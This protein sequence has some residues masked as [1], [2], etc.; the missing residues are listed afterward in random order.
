MRKLINVLV[1]G[2]IVGVSS[3]SFAVTVQG[4]SGTT[5]G[6]L[7]P[8]DEV[9]LRQQLGQLA[10]AFGIETK[11]PDAP[12]QSAQPAANPPAEEKKTMAEV[13]DKA[14]DMASGLVASVAATLQKVAPQVWRIMIKQQYA[15]AAGYLIVP[16]GLVLLGVIYMS[17]I[18]SK[19]SA[20]KPDADR[21]SREDSEERAA[22]QIITT[23]LPL[24][25]I[26]LLGI[27][28]VARLGDAIQRLINPEYYAIRDLLTM[29]LSSTG[30]TPLN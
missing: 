3:S 18:R 13:A 6:A 30:G 22:R 8:Q 11:K 29:L 12:V 26:C 25:I 1:I 15:N 27:W 23:A 10:G 2:L 5:N 20:P 16:W 19:W 7:S 24:V 21:E 17:I 14:L 4:L 9:K 28:G